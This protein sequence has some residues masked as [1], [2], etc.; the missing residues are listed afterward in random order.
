[1]PQPKPPKEHTVLLAIIRVAQAP[2]AS[3]IDS[4][5]GKKVSDNRRTIS[6]KKS[7]ALEDNALYEISGGQERRWL[8]DKRIFHWF[9]ITSELLNDSV[10]QLVG[11]IL[12][13]YHESPGS[14]ESWWVWPAI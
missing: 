5:G 6:N 11:I 1:M 12:R 3:A 7:N 2:E 8:M 14:N 13:K 9:I 4:S 10:F